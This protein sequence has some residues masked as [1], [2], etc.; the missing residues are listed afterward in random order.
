MQ[1]CIVFPVTYEQRVMM[2][3][4]FYDKLGIAPLQRI[5]RICLV[6]PLDK[7]AIARKF[8]RD[9]IPGYP[10]EQ[11][12][13]IEFVDWNPKEF[14][15]FDYIG[16]STIASD[17]PE[18]ADDSYLSYSNLQCGQCQYVHDNIDFVPKF[19]PGKISPQKVFFRLLAYDLLYCREA[20]RTHY[21]ELGLTGLAFR[22]LDVKSPNVFYK[23][24]PELHRWKNRD[25]VCSACETKTNVRTVEMFMLDEEYKYDF[26]MQRTVQNHFVVSRKGT[27]LLLKFCRGNELHPAFPVMP[28]YMRDR[29]VFHNSM[30]LFEDRYNERICVPK[31][32]LF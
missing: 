20:F 21:M 12:E 10:F 11:E 16:Y 17:T 19:H 22:K 26:Q 13:I 14:S 5:G 32:H 8:I 28:G 2:E 7:L 3:A 4:D 1:M 25:G 23:V 9:R 15:E 18:S 24:I 27:E 31:T 6:S 29:F 30:F